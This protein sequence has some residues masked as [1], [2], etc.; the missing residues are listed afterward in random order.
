MQAHSVGMHVA[1]H[2]IARAL[3]AVTGGTVE[4]VYY[5]SE[6]TLPFKAE[7][8]QG[9]R[10]YRG[11]KHGKRGGRERLEVSYRLVER[12]EDR[13]LRRPT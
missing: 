6:T 10:F 13:I 12:P 5:K 7:L 8:G 11:R 3:V 2:E 4:N 1:R 9:K